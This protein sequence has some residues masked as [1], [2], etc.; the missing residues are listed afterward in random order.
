MKKSAI[1][2][3]GSVLLLF[4]G[5][6]NKQ[7]SNKDHLALTCMLNHSKADTMTIVQSVLNKLHFGI[8]KA[9]LNEGLVTT[10]PLSG[11]NFFEFWRKDTVGKQNI[12]E[13]NLHTIRRIVELNITQQNNDCL[14]QCKVHTQR[15][16][17]PYNSATQTSAYRMLSNSTATVPSLQLSA[18]QKQNMTWTDLGNDHALAQKIINMIKK[19]AQKK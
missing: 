19:D 15:L 11:A 5:C 7:I 10:L 17:V 6:S 13:S 8:A 1:L 18:Y 3:L 16:N 2:C 12:L 9:D 4:S 14:V